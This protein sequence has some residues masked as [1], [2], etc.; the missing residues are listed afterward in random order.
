[1]LRI[2]FAD[3]YFTLWNVT[4]STEYSNAGG[5]FL[6]YQ[7]TYFNYLK[8]LAMDEKKAKTKAIL[9]GVEHFDVD[10]DLRG[11]SASFVT[12][13]AMFSKMPTEKSPFFEFGKYDGKKITEIN[14]ENHLFWYFM[15]TQNIHCRRRLL[16]DFGF[17]EWNDQIVSGEHFEKISK[18][19]NIE[20]T[21]VEN[22]EFIGSLNSN[23]NEY[24]VGRIDVDGELFHCR[25]PKSKS[26]YYN[27]RNFFIPVQ[28][29]KGKRIKGKPALFKIG[30]VDGLDFDFEIT[31]F[32]ILKNQIIY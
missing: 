7:K 5:V 22:R 31:E 25:F 13:R 18:R 32:E 23:L 2:G 16:S 11:K 30:R 14:D 21:I 29:G 27:G 24:G 12:D 6:P 4:T 26:Q 3:K 15:Q 28:N 9:E 19:E 8:N 10:H 1:M 17:V 20:K